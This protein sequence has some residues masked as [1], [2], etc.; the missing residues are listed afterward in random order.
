MLEMKTYKNWK[1]ICEAMNWSTTGGGYKS[2]I[3]KNFRL[4]VQIP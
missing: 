4:N 1:E 2:E 3:S